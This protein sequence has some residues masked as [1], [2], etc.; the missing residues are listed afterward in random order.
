MRTL[1]PD[2][3]VGIGGSAGSLSAFIALLEAMPSDTGMA[4]IIV[5]HL[6]TTGDSLQGVR[7]IN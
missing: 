3:V 1:H 2:F 7:M 4:F 5:A 6:P